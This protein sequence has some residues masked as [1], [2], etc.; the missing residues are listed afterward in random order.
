MK[1]SAEDF[2]SSLIAVGLSPTKLQ[3]YI[4]ET[5]NTDITQTP[6][7]NRIN[8]MRQS[9]ELPL[10]S[11][12]SVQDGTNLRG[13]STLYAADGS[14]KVQWVKTDARKEDELTYFKEA[15]DNFVSSPRVQASSV[16]EPPTSVDNDTMSIYSIGDAHIG[17]MAYGK[18]TG[19]DYDSTILVADLLA[20]INLLVDQAHPSKEAFIIDVGD[21]YQSDSQSNT[22]TAGTRVDVDSRFSKMIQVGLDLAVSL[23]ERALLKHE[24]VRWRSAIG[25]HNSHS[26]IYVTS[27]LQAWFRNNSRVIIHDTPAMFMYHQFGRNLIG[28]THG[29]T[30][31]AEKL[32]EIMSVDQKHLWSATD[33]RYFYTGHVHHQSVK[34]FT[35]CVVETFNTLTGKDAW[36]AASGYRSKQ[37]MKSITLHR[38]YG[39]I[40][41]NTVNQALIRSTLCK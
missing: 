2:K 40:S 3:K 12:N 17:M 29:H 18:E 6:I 8:R 5:Y 37:S 24:T 27:F 15:I 21:Y 25:N 14:V 10:Q 19:E 13:T 7:S 11:G 34:E 35:N 26:A 39:E 32:G 33:H 38:E 36:H 20:A 1:I 23:I 22:T 31:K 4:K 9:G 28:I 16:I 41:R 30:V